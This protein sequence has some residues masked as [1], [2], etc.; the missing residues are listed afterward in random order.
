MFKQFLMWRFALGQSPDGWLV[1][2]ST[3]EDL[4]DEAI[5]ARGR[6]NAELLRVDPDTV[7]VVYLHKATEEEKA[8]YLNWLDLALARI[9]SGR[10]TFG[11]ANKPPEDG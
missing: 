1:L 4:S 2:Y 7:R 5:L 9:D 11:P 10:A 6:A 8:I 3:N